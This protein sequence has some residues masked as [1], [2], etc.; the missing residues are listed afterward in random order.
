VKFYSPSIAANACTYLLLGGLGYLAYG[1]THP[2]AALPHEDV[3]QISAPTPQN[4]RSIL[5]FRERQ[6]PNNANRPTNI[7]MSIP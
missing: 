1:D 6:A 3:A 4:R 2:R 5:R 7:P